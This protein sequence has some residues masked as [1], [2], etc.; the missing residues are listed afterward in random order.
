MSIGFNYLQALTSQSP[1]KMDIANI[2][3]GGLGA[4]IP[5]EFKQLKACGAS[6]ITAG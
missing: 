2:N 3:P 5:V 1:S 6:N 4:H